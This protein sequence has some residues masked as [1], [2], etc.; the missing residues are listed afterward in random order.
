MPLA[1]AG[2]L[3]VA[4]PLFIS[5]TSEPPQPSRSTPAVAAAS[6]HAAPV[7]EKPDLSCTEATAL[8]PEQFIELDWVRLNGPSTAALGPTAIGR[9]TTIRTTLGL[10]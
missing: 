6:T 4:T 7:T 10:K 2:A 5:G 3:L 8:V 9:T 1:F